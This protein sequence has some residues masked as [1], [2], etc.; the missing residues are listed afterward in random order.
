MKYKMAED[1]E[2]IFDCTD[3]PEPPKKRESKYWD[4]EVQGDIR[5]SKSFENF[6]SRNYGWRYASVKHIPYIEDSG[7]RSTTLIYAS[8]YTCVILQLFWGITQDLLE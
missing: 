4:L 3:Y 5:F 8:I 6:L 7:P 1:P 2:W